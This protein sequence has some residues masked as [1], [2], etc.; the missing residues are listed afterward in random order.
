M[1][2]VA[3]DVLDETGLLK[4][5]EVTD[6]DDIQSGRSGREKRTRDVENFFSQPYLKDDDGPEPK[7][8]R[9]CHLC[10]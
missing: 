3:R 4:D 10:S 1:A 9:D 8:Y 2:A 5:I 7:K 6:V